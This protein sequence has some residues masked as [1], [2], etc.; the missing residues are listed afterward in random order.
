MT[1]A[2]KQILTYL[3][4]LAGTIPADRDEILDDEEIIGM[5]DEIIRDVAALIKANRRGDFTKPLT[6]DEIMEAHRALRLGK[7]EELF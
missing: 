2:G 7:Q 6:A 5:P 4:D 1:L 3:F